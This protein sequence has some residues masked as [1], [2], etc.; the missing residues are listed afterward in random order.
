MSMR[1]LF[2]HTDPDGSSVE[3]LTLRGHG[4]A[5]VIA[6]AEEDENATVNLPR[7]RVVELHEALGRWLDRS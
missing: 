5:L 1:R 7:E 6:A 2:R 4:H 3:F